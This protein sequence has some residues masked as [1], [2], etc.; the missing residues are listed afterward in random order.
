MKTMG[1][2]LIL[3]FSIL[4][5]LILYIFRND[6]SKAQTLIVALTLLVLL[7]YAIDTNRIADSTSK[8]YRAFWISQ[9]FNNFSLRVDSARKYISGIHQ[10]EA[11]NIHQDDLLKYF[12]IFIE[13]WPE[14]K[15]K[16]F[17]I[18][19]KAEFEDFCNKFLGVENDKINDFLLKLKEE[20]GIKVA[21]LI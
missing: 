18:E 15:G 11:W 13:L 21:K 17:L 3:L 2:I 12:D 4:V 10:D 1:F 14:K 6:F 16:Q 20:L 7:F 5:G 19:K 8:Q 9:Y